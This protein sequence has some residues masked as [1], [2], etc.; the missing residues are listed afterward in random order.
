VFFPPPQFERKADRAMRE[1][2]ARE[3]CGECPVVEECLDYALEIREPHGIW[4]GLNETERRAIL[5]Q[6]ASTSA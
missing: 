5:D 1:T 4:G 2:R 6:R 3:I